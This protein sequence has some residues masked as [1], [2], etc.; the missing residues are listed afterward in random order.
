MISAHVLYG[1][2]DSSKRHLNSFFGVY[3]RGESFG[4]LMVER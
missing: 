2:V 1:A 4:D 3:G